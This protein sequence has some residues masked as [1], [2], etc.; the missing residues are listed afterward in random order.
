MHET[1]LRRAAR[2]PGGCGCPT[3]LQC[4]QNTHLATS[5]SVIALLRVRI[6]GNLLLSLHGACSATAGRQLWPR[7]MSV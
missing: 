5:E 6:H 3:T 7:G 4:T 1:G 2:Q